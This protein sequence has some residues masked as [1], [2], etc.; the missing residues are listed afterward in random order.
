MNGFRLGGEFCDV[1]LEQGAQ[2]GKHLWAVSVCPLARDVRLAGEFREQ[3]I[4]EWMIDRE[5]RIIR[6]EIA[7]RD[8]GRGL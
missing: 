1:L 5:A 3:G 8:I 4:D 6:L 7:L 2:A